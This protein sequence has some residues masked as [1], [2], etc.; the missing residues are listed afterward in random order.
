MKEILSKLRSLKKRGIRM[1]IDPLPLFVKER[2]LR[3]SWKEG[4]VLHL[5][6]LFF[7]ER[8]DHKVVGV[9]WD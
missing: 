5:T 3:V 4:G 2:G 6:P 9:S 1:G 8:G 7:K